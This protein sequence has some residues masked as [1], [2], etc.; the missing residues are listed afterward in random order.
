[1]EAASRLR[2]LRQAAAARRRWST[3]RGIRPCRSGRSPSAPHSREAVLLRWTQRRTTTTHREARRGLQERTGAATRGSGGEV[4][5]RRQQPRRQWRRG[6][7]GVRR[8]E[9]E[10][11]PI[12][13]LGTSPSH[14]GARNGGLEEEGGLAAAPKFHPA[15]RGSFLPRRFCGRFVAQRAQKWPQAIV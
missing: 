12:I 3:L 1:M 11:I 8:G 2:A 6:A 10:G 9:E 7:R 14:L 5:R 4:S 15:M 13:T